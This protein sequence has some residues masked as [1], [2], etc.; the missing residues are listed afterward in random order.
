MSRRLSLPMLLAGAAA[1]ITVAACDGARAQ[2]VHEHEH[3]QQHAHYSAGEPGE[4]SK[5]ARTVAIE[6][7]DAEGKMAFAPE[8]IEVSK[9]EQIRFVLS[10]AGALE[11]EFVLASKADNSAHAEMMKQMAPMQ[12]DQ[13]NGKRLASKSAGEIVWKFTQAGEFE[14]ACLIPGHYEVGMHGSVV[15]K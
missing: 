5:P 1:W 12:H 6:M 10:N 4:A 14:F 13:P 11:H 15:V 3:A 8:R 2:E 7:R 9:G